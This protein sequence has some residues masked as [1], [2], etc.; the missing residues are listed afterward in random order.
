MDISALKTGEVEWHSEDNGP[1][2]AE[3]DMPALT[4]CTGPPVPSL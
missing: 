2:A 4:L 1:A 3:R